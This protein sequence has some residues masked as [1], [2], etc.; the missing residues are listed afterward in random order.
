LC[1]QQK[2]RPFDT[3]TVKRHKSAAYGEEDTNKTFQHFCEFQNDNKKLLFRIPGARSA[4]F[5][6]I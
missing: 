3:A 5:K 6:K 2:T 4:V 1:T